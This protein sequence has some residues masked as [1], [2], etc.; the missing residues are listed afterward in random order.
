[1]RHGH[2][3]HRRRGLVAVGEPGGR[4]ETGDTRGQSDGY[5]CDGVTGGEHPVPLPPGAPPL[6]VLPSRGAIH[7][8]D[9]PIGASPPIAQTRD[10]RRRPR[11]PSYRTTP[12]GVV[13]G[14]PPGRAAL[15]GPRCCGADRSRPSGGRHPSRRHPRQRVAAG[16]DEHAREPGDRRDACC[17]GGGVHRPTTSSAGQP[18]TLGVGMPVERLPAS[19]GTSP[20]SADA[21]PSGRAWRLRDGSEAGPSAVGLVGPRADRRRR[22]RRRRR[23][24]R[25]VRRLDRT[26]RRRG[27]RG[28]RRGVLG[29]RAHDMPPTGVTGR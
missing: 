27:R 14:P 3:R 20:V 2:R 23:R 29:V 11:S 19:V 16:H 15:L 8:G 6:V 26:R 18:S 12:D 10:A 28:A 7:C 5:D 21:T 9:A 25:R 22:R 24:G 4:T 1:M 17:C 13:S